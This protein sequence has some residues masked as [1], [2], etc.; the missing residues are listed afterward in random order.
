MKINLQICSLISWENTQNS[1]LESIPQVNLDIGTEFTPRS[2]GSTSDNQNNYMDDIKEDTIYTRLF[3]SFTAL[4]APCLICFI[5][6][7]VICG[8]DSNHSFHAIY[9][10]YTTIL[11]P[12]WLNTN[13]ISLCDLDSLTCINRQTNMHVIHIGRPGCRRL[14]LSCDYCIFPC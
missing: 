2:A 11:S 7:D 9:S 1:L 3:D 12:G 10:A 6:A 5:Y 13:R 4:H 14:A 8:L